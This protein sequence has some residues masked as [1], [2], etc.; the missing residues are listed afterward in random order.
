MKGKLTEAL[1]KTGDAHKS[2][3]L[4]LK[5]YATTQEEIERAKEMIS[6]IG[7]ALKNVNLNKLDIS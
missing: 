6:N 1:K 7:N 2:W 4:F 5:N 3:I